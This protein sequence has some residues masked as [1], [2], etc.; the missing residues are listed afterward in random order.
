[1]QNGTPLNGVV[2]LAIPVGL[3]QEEADE[4]AAR[5]VGLFREKQNIPELAAGDAVADLHARFALQAYHRT[6]GALV[7][8]DA[9]AAPVPAADTVDAAR[10]VPGLKAGA[11]ASP[12]TRPRGDIAVVGMAGRYPQARTLAEFWAHLRDGRD[13]ITRD[14]RGAHAPPRRPCADAALPRRLHRPG[15]PLRLAVLQHLAARGRDAGSGRSGCSWRWPGRRWRTPATTPRALRRTRRRAVSACSSARSGPCTR[16]WAPSRSSPAA[17]LN[18]NSF[19][20]SIANRVSYWMN[21]S[22]PSLTVDTAC[23]S[24]L[25]ALHLACEAI[26]NGECSSALVGGVNLDLHQHKI[27]HQPRRRC[28]VRRWRVPHLRRRGQRLRG[29]RGRR[30]A[31][32]EAAGA[33]A[34]RPRPGLRRDQGRWR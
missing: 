3:K 22:G 28:A 15:R 27:R 26:H 24:S 13:C 2:R 5:L 9:V 34:G 25:T 12:A 16:W 18:P 7:P 31:L 23:S 6:R 19:L 8:I 11:A 30:R 21:L 33:G 1:M 32:P 20:W 10:V 4:I 29:R 17:E 14:P